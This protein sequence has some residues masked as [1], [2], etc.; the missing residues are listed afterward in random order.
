MGV[1][2][3]VTDVMV[4]VGDCH[5]GGWLMVMEVGAAMLVVGGG[6]HYVWCCVVEVVKDC[7]SDGDGWLMVVVVDVGS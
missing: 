6:F 2:V 3:G 1:G 4:V 7:H 5:S